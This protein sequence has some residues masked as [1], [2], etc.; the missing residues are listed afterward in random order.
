VIYNGVELG[1]P[2]LSQSEWRAKLGIAENVPL[3]V[4][5]ANWRTVKGHDVLL[6]AWKQM[7]KNL[8]VGA[9][10]PRL[11]LAGALLDG[12]EKIISKAESMGLLDES[13]LIQGSIADVAGL[14]GSADLGVLTS[15][16]EGLPNAILE[17]MLAG[18]S[19]I[20]SDLPGVRDALGP[21]SASQTFPVGDVNALADMLK[22]FVLHPEGLRQYV[23]ANRE[24]VQREFSVENMCRKTTDVIA[25]LL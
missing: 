25:E 19:V 21:N 8:P 17:Y 16:H 4:M 12:S 10:A 3:V 2:D 23:S 5:L 1:E 6:Q 14:L 13:V 11:V 18:L 22:S 9:A 20:A 15:R 7:L 24:R